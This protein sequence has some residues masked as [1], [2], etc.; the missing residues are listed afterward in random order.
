MKYNQWVNK[1]I[2]TTL[3]ILAIIFTMETIVMN[4]IL[5]LNLD[6]ADSIESIIDAGLLTL[7]SAPLI[8]LL[9]VR[10]ITNRLKKDNKTLSKTLLAT[11]INA[12]VMKTTGIGILITD[13]KTKIVSINPGLSR[14]TG[15]S[16]EELL[17][18]T[19]RVLHSGKQD[20][21]FYQQMWQSILKTGSWQGELYNKRKDGSIYLQSSSITE[22][23]DES[24]ENKVTNY[25]GIVQDITAEKILKD[26]LIK[27]ARFDALTGISN[28]TAFEDGLSNAIA[29]VNRHKKQ[30]A[31]F[32]LDVDNFKEVNDTH[33]H[34]TGDKLL[35]HIANVLKSLIRGVDLVSRFGG[36]E[37]A[38]V[39]VYEQ[40][41]DFD[42]TASLL[43]EK[44]IK[45]LG[46]PI[47]INN[48]VF[49][50]Q[51][52]IGISLAPQDSLNQEQLIKLAD[53][54]MYK[55]KL[56]D[57]SAYVFWR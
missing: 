45:H 51:V 27:K 5:S 41:R 32:F 11:N 3:L 22:V 57:K 21:A 28:R 13:A 1:P 48:H 10:P 56:K 17:G 42:K 25:I 46:E 40:S 39:F 38:L 9:I 24:K 43:A 34:G 52:S 23:R 33:G 31:V 15:L 20:K 47:T 26:E 30:L 4:I 14:L 8:L 12:E 7:T 36:D 2:N 50:T 49:A 29:Q 16:E 19:P 37:F 18:E 35:Q 44:I 53:K 6:V 54:A 55:A